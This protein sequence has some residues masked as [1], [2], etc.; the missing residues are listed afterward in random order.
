MFVEEFLVK[1]FNIEVPVQFHLFRLPVVAIF[2]VDMLYDP[3]CWFEHVAREWHGDR[4]HS[5]MS[6]EKENRQMTL[7]QDL[8]NGIK[9]SKP[10]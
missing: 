8:G 10:N 1:Y 7:C 9:A 4:S 2:T 5:S 3:L 6:E